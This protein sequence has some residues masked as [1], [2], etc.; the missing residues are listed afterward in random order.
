MLDHGPQRFDPIWAILHSVASLLA[1][2]DTDLRCLFANH[3]FERWFGVSGSGLIGNSLQGLLGPEQFA[4]IEPHVRAALSGEIRQFEHLVPG[5]EGVSRPGLV[6]FIPYVVDGRIVGFAAEVND[7]AP[8]QAVRDALARKAEEASRTTTELR[9]SQRALRTAQRLAEIGSWEWD[10]RTGVI[11]WSEQ[12]YE[13]F[14]LDPSRPPPSIDDHRQLYTPRSFDDL[15][16]AIQRAVHLGLPHS[17]ELE[18]I[19]RSG[20]TGWIEGRGNVE[21]NASGRTVRLYGTI[22]EVTARRI[23]RTAAAADVR[24]RELEDELDMLRTENAELRRA[25]RDRTP[26]VRS[27]AARLTGF[28]KRPKPGPA[29]PPHL[30]AA[31]MDVLRLYD[32]V[33]CGLLITDA[34]GQI[35]QV[36][37]T[38]AHWVGRDTSALIHHRR[39]QD[40]LTPE[41]KQRYQAELLPALRLDGMVME[42][43][44]AIVSA[45]G[46]AMPMLVNIVRRKMDGRTFDAVVLVAAGEH[47]EYE[48]ELLN[49]R[50]RAHQVAMGERAAREAFEAAQAR[51]QQ[52][53]HLGALY[54][55]SIDPATGRRQYQDGVAF[56]LG[57][58]RAAPVTHE[59]ILAAMA[60]ADREASA[61]RLQAVLARKEETYHCTY[62]L[63]GVDGVLRTVSSIGQAFFAEDGSLAHFAGV[64]SDQTDATLARAA[65]EDRAL[66]A[67]Q[68]IGIVSHDLRNPLTT[69]LTG[70][71]VLERTALPAETHAVLARIRAAA[72]R[73]GRLVSDLLDFTRVRLAGGL[74]IARQRVDLQAVVS[75]CVAE[76]GFTLGTRIR[77][78][79]HGATACDVDPDRLAQLV[80]NLV[81]NAAHYGSPEGPIQVM[82]RIEGDRV[83]LSVHNHGGP[84][85][86]EM[87]DILF[88]PMSRGEG[89]PSD[90]QRSVG[91]GLYI[92]KA[93]ATAHGGTVSV[94]S[95]AEEGTTFIVDLPRFA[96][97]ATSPPPAA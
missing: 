64:L 37:A 81:S 65:A 51:L 85:A 77:H 55:W 46:Q 75:D 73:A 95:T 93:I 72:Q 49:S 38:F 1:F 34:M 24:A 15:V 35:T 58:A 17:L 20:R 12:Q 89:R 6:S 45:A 41:G 52:A 78:E 22:Q 69:V 79:H 59:Q 32:D 43:T 94:R 7:L 25:V 61:Q 10:L 31:A 68:M 14:G 3:A 48:Q 47:S 71:Q 42:T 84:I 60:T 21:R 50:Q 97:S 23:A 86:P 30:M 96:Q 27:P 54:G 63:H 80:G 36:N 28:L 2:W 70:V 90:A 91:L 16:D 88:H 33:P 29:Y 83:Q 11:T 5:P 40:F 4:L 13:I 87:L 39:L 82:S 8:L 53:M 67:E 62:H 26:T 92:V 76:S 44:L 9:K 74:P 56:L 57:H 18:Y 66:L 19:H